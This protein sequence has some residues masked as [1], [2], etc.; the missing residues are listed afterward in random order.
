MCNSLTS[1]CTTNHVKILP[2]HSLNN[3]IIQ[4]R[5]NCRA[6][7]YLLKKR[8]STSDIL[9]VMRCS[10]SFTVHN[11]Q[12]TSYF[13]HLMRL[14]N[15]KNYWKNSCNTRRRKILNNDK[16]R[17]YRKRSTTTMAVLHKFMMN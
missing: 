2:K 6:L 11:A 5:N 9:V 12:D 16:R 15:K 8:F 7:S 17:Q 14:K 3:M 1:H 13:V 4:R 10:P